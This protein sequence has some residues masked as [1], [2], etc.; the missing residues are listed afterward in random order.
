MSIEIVTVQMCRDM[1]GRV[2]TV[3]GSGDKEY[4]VSFSMQQGPHCTCEGF[5]YR[6]DCKHIHQVSFCDWNQQ[7]SD[8]TLE[9]DGVCPRCGGPTIGCRVAV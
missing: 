9:T 8:E 4:R 5:K 6:K 3:K 2:V 1:D 7:W